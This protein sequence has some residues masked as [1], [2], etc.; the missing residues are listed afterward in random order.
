MKAN[1]SAFGNSCVIAI[2]SSAYNSRT[3]CD[4]NEW[5]LYIGTQNVQ[6]YWPDKVANIVGRAT[7]KL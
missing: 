3:L 7:S 2:F 6:K 4:N 5:P 1:I